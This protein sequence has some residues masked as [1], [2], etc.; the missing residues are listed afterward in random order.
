M[1]LT[2]PKHTE[3]DDNFLSILFETL[4]VRPE[5]ASVFK[6]WFKYM[7]VRDNEGKN[8]VD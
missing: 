8:C 6:V 4:F 3:F 1:W 7:Q 2:L 5:D